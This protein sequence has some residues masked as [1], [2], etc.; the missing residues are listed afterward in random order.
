MAIRVRAG[1]TNNVPSGSSRSFA[2][3]LR[4]SL[5]TLFNA[6][7]GAGTVV[8][9]LFGD[10]QDGLFGLTALANVLIGVFQEFRAKR[11]LDSLSLL[12]ATP[13]RVLRGGETHEIGTELVVLDDL[14]VLRV[15]DQVPADAV[16][17]SEVGLEIDQSQLTGE[18]APVGKRADDTVLSGS[19]VAAGHGTAR[20]VRV[21]ADS[22]TSRL[23]AEAKRFSLVN[24]ELRN[25][26]NRIVRWV[27][28][29]LAPLII[30]VMNAQMHAAGG[31]DT[32]IRSGHWRDALIGT[33]ASASS[34]IPQGLIL[35]ISISFALA[36]AKLAQSQVLVQEI[37]AIEILARVDTLCF[38]KT[39]TLTDGAIAFDGTH[40]IETEGGKAG[41]E[42]ADWKAV[43]GCFGADDDANATARC[44]RAAFQAG[45]LR[46]S[47]SVPFTSEHKWS[48]VGIPQ[49]ASRGTWVLGAPEMVFAHLDDTHPAL[50]K[51]LSGLLARGLRTLVLAHSDDRLGGADID[52]HR[53]PGSLQPVAL[54]TFAE[55]IRPDAAETV[56]YFQAQGVALKVISGD[57]PHTAATIARAVGIQLE[58]SGY[59]ARDLPEDLGAMGEV[60]ETNAVFGRVTPA[61]KRQ[62]VRALQQRG[63]VV[64]MTGDG[65]ND[66]LALKAADIGI[67]MG[68]GAPATKAVARMILLDG[69]FSRLPRVVAEGR[70]VI[71]NIERVSKLFLTKTTY[72]VL[73][74]IA[75][76]VLLWRFP[77]LPR[78]FAPTDGLTIGIPALLLALAGQQKP[79]RPGFLRR[80]LRFSLPAG[81]VTATVIVVVLAF[82]RVSGEYSSSEM[83]TAAAIALSIVGFWVLVVSARPLTARRYALL[84]TMVT[85]Q[86]ACFLVPL[87][88]TFLAFTLPT[89]PLLSV[90][91]GIAAT[92]CIAV[93]IVFRLTSRRAPL[94]VVPPRL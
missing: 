35:M 77:F 5:F 66:A 51:K 42:Q 31:W 6:V 47:G 33:V 17:V 4:A 73:L 93:E 30:L 83:S 18:T 8:L 39:G 40:A 15:G 34:V 24:S 9:I 62:M 58:G 2:H 1:A 7:V 88:R 94:S 29:G 48:A 81:A 45:D 57:N 27:S 67:A 22:Y 44:L 46:P 74:S 86:A 85:V 89:G 28:W 72:A 87:V 84:A 90:S 49:G 52:G 16:I 43:L 65:V 36:A 70:R 78:Q 63:H 82:A 10:W 3:I 41:A 61:Q 92:G 19:A 50:Q 12:N 23:T 13:A 37:A 68:S 59:D 71:V 64:A 56:A 14:L 21:G 76:G 11:L 38:D 80:S 75:V 25:A 20:V 60:L 54:V 53:L 26:A 69:Q 91:F 32:A 55:T 79:Y